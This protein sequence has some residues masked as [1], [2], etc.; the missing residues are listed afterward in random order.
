MLTDIT[1]TLIPGLLQAQGTTPAWRARLT[2][3]DPAAAFARALGPEWRGLV[4]VR[5]GKPRQ[6]A[7]RWGNPRWPADVL[8][9]LL[10]VLDE[11]KAGEREARAAV[12]RLLAA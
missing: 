6:A 2:M 7:Q 5:L 3:S 11:R 12:A 4:A 8:A 10:R 1:T 9:E